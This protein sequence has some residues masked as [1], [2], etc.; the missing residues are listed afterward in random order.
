[1]DLKRGF[2]TG[3]TIR[4][5]RRRGP[6]PRVGHRYLD[7]RLG[8]HDFQQLAGRCSQISSLTSSQW[9]SGRPMEV[10]TAQWDHDNRVKFS[11]SDVDREK[12]VDLFVDVTADEVHTAGTIHRQASAPAAVGGA[13]A[14]CARRRL[15]LWFAAL[16]GK[17]K[18]T[19]SQYVCQAHRS[20]FVPEAVTLAGKW[21]WTIRRCPA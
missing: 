9:R 7:E 19:L 14:C 3:E 6:C 21:R 20:S 17:A 13:A 16:Q 8:D 18:S 1:M 15:S 5:E 11:Q 4:L 10:A 2:P 12:V